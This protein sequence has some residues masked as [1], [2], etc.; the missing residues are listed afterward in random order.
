MTFD[1]QRPVPGYGNIVNDSGKMLGQIPDLQ[2]ELRFAAM[3]TTLAE[4]VANKIQEDQLKMYKLGVQSQQSQQ[5]QGG[6]DWL[7]LAK[8]G[9]SLAK[10]F[11][12]F[13][14]GGGGAG[15]GGDSFAGVDN[16]VLDSVLGD[17]GTYGSSSS[18]LF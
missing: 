3:N 4:E 18:G 6:T 11:G 16:S 5:G 9:F 14:G 2:N 13:G 10:G 17:A 15:L 8:Q 12:A 7:G 1:L